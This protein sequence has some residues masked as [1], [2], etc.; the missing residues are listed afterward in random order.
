[1]KPPKLPT[2]S[3]EDGIEVEIFSSEVRRILRNFPMEPG[4]AVE[5]IMQVLTGCARQEVLRNDTF[6]AT[7]DAILSLLDDAFGD[8][9]GASTLQSTFHNRRQGATESI[10][11]YAQQLKLLAERVNI[12]RPGCIDQETLRDRFADG[13]Y[14]SALRRDIRR[15]IREHPGSNLS[16]ARKEAQRWLR[17]DDI[18]EPSIVYQQAVQPTEVTSLREEIAALTKR[19]D[20]ALTANKGNTRRCFYCSKPGHLQ[21]D[22]F[23]RKRDQSQQPQLHEPR[24]AQRAEN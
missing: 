8:R 3:G 15:F 7:P 11:E 16:D 18:E 14:S 5:W 13:L 19:L 17:E 10:L 24:Q 2:F 21:A 1:M 23:K 4:V 9:R 12:K 22:C 6:P 20:E